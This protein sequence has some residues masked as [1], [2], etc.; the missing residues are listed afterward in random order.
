MKI[1]VFLLMILLII[2]F[3]FVAVVS[4]AVFSSFL[5]NRRVSS[6]AEFIPVYFSG[7]CFNAEVASSFSARMKGLMYRESLAEDTGMIFSF[8]GE[9]RH[10][11]WMKNTLI[12]LDIIW[13]S[14][15]KEIVYIAQNVQPCKSIICPSVSSDKPAKYVL[16]INGGKADET[17]LKIGDK[18]NFDL[19]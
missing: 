2:V 10:A 11:F 8:S 15:N 12:P 19:R 6:E 1:K 4:I 5:D 13:I 7:H 16:E 3:V 17:G 9:D 18:A 14:E